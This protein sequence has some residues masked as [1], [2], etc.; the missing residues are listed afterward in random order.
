MF[1]EHGDADNVV[2][3]TVRYWPIADIGFCA[4]HVCF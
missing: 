2:I 4:A 3:R 1:E